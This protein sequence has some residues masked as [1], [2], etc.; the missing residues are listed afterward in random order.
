[1]LNTKY[2]N[3]EGA[4]K[5]FSHPV[6]SDWLVSLS[7]DASLLDLGCGYGRLTPELKK[8]GFCN[9]SGYDFSK[10]LIE[11][12]KRENPG[13]LYTSNVGELIGKTFDAVL[14]FALFTSCPAA[15]D[16][17]ELAALIDSLTC[18]GSLLYISDYETDDNPKYSERYKQKECDKYGCFKSG[19]AIFRHH[20]SGHFDN[21]FLNWRKT[22]EK[23][24]N[25][26]TM[27]KNRIVIHQYLYT[28][29]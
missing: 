13:P 22:R 24:L 7:R 4:Q 5:V 27:N 25:G 8:E 26:K 1:M 20:K 23:T 2:W 10:P 28:K 21:L 18:K 11:R 19:S 17:L 12:A 15:K 6:S 14:C 16:Q 3:S 9:L 29:K